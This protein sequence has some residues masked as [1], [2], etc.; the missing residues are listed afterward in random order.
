M[1]EFMGFCLGIF[2]LCAAFLAII[3]ALE[4]I[5]YMYILDKEEEDAG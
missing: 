2:F 1:S 5:Q 4:R 3:L